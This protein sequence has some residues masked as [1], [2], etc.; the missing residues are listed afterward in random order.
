MLIALHYSVS[1]WVCMCACRGMDTIKNDSQV[2]VGAIYSKQRTVSG[3]V[4]L[5]WGS[6]DEDLRES[7]VTFQL[8]YLRKSYRIQ[9]TKRQWYI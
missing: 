8:W 3:R 5:E 7:G 9:L 6:V 1:L 4:W 2:S